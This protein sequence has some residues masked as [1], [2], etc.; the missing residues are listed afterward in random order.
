MKSNQ[1]A[2]QPRV[3]ASILYLYY[4]SSLY[5]F[6]T[7]IYQSSLL[8]N[9][10]FK[11]QVKES[12]AGMISMDST[13]T[14]LQLLTFSLRNCRTLVN[15]KERNPFSDFYSKQLIL[16][17]TKCLHSAGM[18]LPPKPWN[19]PVR[20]I[21]LILKLLPSHLIQC[22]REGLFTGYQKGN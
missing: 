12:K 18:E 14:F 6:K 21:F 8:S 19:F 1:A 11:I 2:S 17:F 4:L 9:L 15:Y 10:L 16:V 20:G 7:F 22:K 5:S 13:G 3:L